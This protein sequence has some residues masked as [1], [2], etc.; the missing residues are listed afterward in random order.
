MIAVRNGRLTLNQVD[1]IQAIQRVHFGMHRSQ[2]IVLE[3]LWA[4]AYHEA[5]HTIIS[6]LRDRLAR[7]QVV[8]IIPSGYALGY[9]WSVDKDDYFHH[10]PSRTELVNDIEV[11]LGGLVAERLH[12]GEN[13][14]GVSSDLRNVARIARAMVRQYGMGSFQFNTSRGFGRERNDRASGETERQIEV[15]IMNIVSDSMKTVEDLLKSKRKELDQMATALVE[16]ETLYFK[17]IVAILE[18]SKT[19]REIEDE[20]KKLSDR[21]LVGKKPVI[22]FDFVSGLATISKGSK[23]GS[24]GGSSSSMPSSESP[25][26]NRTVSDSVDDVIEQSGD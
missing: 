25:S 13:T 9:M 2:N 24:N 17:D 21:K 5:G 1:I 15:E 7:I 8:T 3:D 23:G 6:Y 11:S 14:A 12:T 26:N 18:P 4:T 19:D 22:D 20:I 16:K 10:S